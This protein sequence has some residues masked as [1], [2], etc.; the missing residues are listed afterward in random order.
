[1]RTAN[2]V[3]ANLN[4][5]R[6]LRNTVDQSLNFVGA[7]LNLMLINE[8]SA[9]SLRTVHV[10]HLYLLI[11]RSAL[12]TE[13]VPLTGRPALDPEIGRDMFTIYGR[14]SAYSTKNVLEILA[15]ALQRILNTA[16]GS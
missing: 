13:G 12:Y 6:K 16:N 7:E 3:A 9:T 2:F 4:Y 10:K 5:F 8:K 11:V 14:S 15:S 1:M